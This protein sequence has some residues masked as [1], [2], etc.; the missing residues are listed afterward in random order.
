MNRMKPAALSGA[1]NLEGHY[2]TAVAAA[3]GHRHISWR[4]ACTCGCIEPDS[5]LPCD[6]REDA[7]ELARAILQE[8]VH[9]PADEPTAPNS[10]RPVPDDV[11]PFVPVGVIR[12]P[13][14]AAEP[15]PELGEVVEIVVHVVDGRLPLRLGERAELEV[16]SITRRI[17]ETLP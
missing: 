9:G 15:D 11:V 1:L 2:P 4:A 14:T 13:V 5:V 7:V 10:G 12:L 17:T 6:L 8:T 16:V 3:G